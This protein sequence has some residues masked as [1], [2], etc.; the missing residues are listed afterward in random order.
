MTDDDPQEQKP[1]DRMLVSKLIDQQVDQVFD[2]YRMLKIWEGIFASS[3]PK[4]LA[5]GMCIA[6]SGGRFIRKPGAAA[7]RNITINVSGD[8]DPETLARSITE[9]IGR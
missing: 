1:A 5:R 7:V 8:V 4:E 9:A 6:L 2:H 3:D